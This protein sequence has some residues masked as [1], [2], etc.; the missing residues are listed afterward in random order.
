MAIG[1]ELKH[2]RTSVEDGALVS[3]PGA[4]GELAHAI[5]GGA[6]I[7]LGVLDTSVNGYKKK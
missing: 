6:V 1:W 2:I 5:N 7:N 3:S 4:F